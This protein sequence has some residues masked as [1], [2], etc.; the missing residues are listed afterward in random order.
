[1]VGL[2]DS[3]RSDLSDAEK[4]NLIRLIEQSKPLP[5]SRF[6]KSGWIAQETGQ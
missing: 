1:M 2:H 3:E 6:E 5:Y 4:A